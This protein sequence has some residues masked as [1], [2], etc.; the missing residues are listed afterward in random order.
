MRNF[1]FDHLL[2][3]LLQE[4]P[5]PRRR[6]YS[7]EQAFTAHGMTSED[8]TSGTGGSDSDESGSSRKFFSPDGCKSIKGAST[9]CSLP[10]RFTGFPWILPVRREILLD[11]LHSTRRAHLRSSGIKVIVGVNQLDYIKGVPQKFQPLE[12]FLTLHPGWIGKVVLVQ[13]AVP[14]GVGPGV[15]SRS[16]HVSAGARGEPTPFKYVDKHS[17]A[18]RGTSFV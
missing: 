13:L 6:S 14:S 17:A 1:Y 11:V 4:Q 3:T 2:V 15:D 10:A 7:R 12:H 9:P 16:G 8:G 5:R 18:F